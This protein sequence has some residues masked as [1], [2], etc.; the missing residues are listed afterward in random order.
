[1]RL[2]DFAGGLLVRPDRIE[3]SLGRAG[4]YRGT[5]KGRMTIT[6]V[7]NRADVRL[8][9]SFEGV[10]AASLMADLGQARWLSGA[11]NGQLNLEG[12][13]ETPAEVVRHA[14]GRAAI[15]IKQGELIGVGLPDLL[16][17]VERRPLA[18]SAEWR[19]GRT[20]F[21]HAAVALN[22]AQG[23]GDVVE[24]YLSAPAIRGTLQGRVSV[25]ERTIAARAAVDSVASPTAP[26][27][28]GPTIVFDITGPLQHVSVVPDVRALINRSD[29]AQPLFGTASSTAARALGFA[30]AAQ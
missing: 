15:S 23:I 4:L 22:V 12:V 29:A 6:T 11:A 16:R 2:D 30:P 24:G 25:I 9:A 13:G 20:P 28:T 7:R 3:A 18:T 17:R 27:S 21:E 8:Q 14:H 26:P 19:G 1:M 10:D 5:G